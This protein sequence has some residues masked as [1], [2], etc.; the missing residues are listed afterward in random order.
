MKKV[1]RVGNEFLGIESNDT[2]SAVYFPK[3][4]S[5]EFRW[6]EEWQEWDFGIKRVGSE[7]DHM[8]IMP[9]LLYLE[10][11]VCKKL[12]GLPKQ[13]LQMTPLE[14]LTVYHCPVLAERYEKGTGKNWL[15]ISHFPNVGFYS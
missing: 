13:L 3:L 14:N 11:R 15:D 12:K 8:T 10:I 5:L 6:M 9:H 7:E 4:K 1:K 2:S